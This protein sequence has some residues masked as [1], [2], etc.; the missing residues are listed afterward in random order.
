MNNMT[1]AELIAKLQEL[2]GDELVQVVVKIGNDDYNRS[3]VVQGA[4][5]IEGTTYLMFRNDYNKPEEMRIHV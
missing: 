2:P 5:S 1:N 4:E 3:R